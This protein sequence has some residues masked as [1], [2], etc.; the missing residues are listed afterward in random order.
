MAAP[1]K[2]TY[3][4]ENVGFDSKNVTPDDY[5]VDTEGYDVKPFPDVPES[6]KKR[7]SKFILD[8]IDKA[9]SISVSDILLH[10]K[11]GNSEERIILPFTRYGNIFSAPNFITSIE[12]TCGAPFSLLKVDTVELDN[13]VIVSMLG[14]VF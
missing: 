5:F 7:T 3:Y 12:D 13:K 2:I 6:I 4:I 11:D 9:S 8:K 14:G 10:S 1:D